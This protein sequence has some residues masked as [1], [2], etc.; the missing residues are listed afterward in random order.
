MLVKVIEN[1]RVAYTGLVGNKLRA[2]LTMLGVTIGI[3]AVIILVSVGQAV[4][5][6]VVE[7]FSSVGANLI[8]VFGE[9]SSTSGVSKGGA[10]DVAIEN[11]FIP[12]TESDVNALRDRARAGY[13]G[14]RAGCCG[15]IDRHL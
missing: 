8:V 14:G 5:S 15:D 6:F 9:I 3:G 2:V 1:V 7:Q 10:G 12:L 13:S 11:L 4:E